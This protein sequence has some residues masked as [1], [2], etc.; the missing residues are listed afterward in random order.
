MKFSHAPLQWSV[1]ER[2][3][4]VS[5]PI[6]LI[7]K[8]RWRRISSK[9]CYFRPLKFDFGPVNYSHITSNTSWTDSYEKKQSKTGWAKKFY[10]TSERHRTLIKWDMAI[11]FAS[12]VSSC[13]EI[14]R[15][16]FLDRSSEPTIR[17]RSEK[18]CENQ[19]ESV[20][21]MENFQC[22]FTNLRKIVTDLSGISKL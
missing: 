5:S 7:E 1:L 13:S 20:W 18:Y 8:L 9:Q 12:E 3:W 16:G 6:A 10:S 21:N 4:F 2:G 17:S 15:T 19:R 22:L 11:L 14:S